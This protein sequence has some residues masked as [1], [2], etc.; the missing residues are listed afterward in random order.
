PLRDAL[1]NAPTVYPLSLA[2]VVDAR[3]VP[4][5]ILSKLVHFAV[6]VFWKASARRWWAVDHVVQLDFGPYETKFRQFLLG[7]ATLPDSTALLVGVSRNPSP[8]VGAIYPYGGGRI[9]GTRQYRFAIPGTSALAKT[10]PPV[11]S[12]NDPPELI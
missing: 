6:G 12:N 9:E 10:F 1:A 5:L 2:E 8:H 7:N 11:L 3:S 4:N